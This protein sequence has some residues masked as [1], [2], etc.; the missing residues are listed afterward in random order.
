MSGDIDP[1][2]RDNQIDTPDDI[3]GTDTS[4]PIHST[5]STSTFEAGIEKPDRLEGL[6]TPYP[7]KSCPAIDTN[8][9]TL[10]TVR[11]KKRSFL[12]HRE[13]RNAFI[14]MIALAVIMVGIFG[15]FVVPKTTL[16]VRTWYSEG[17]FGTI[18]V[19]VLI[20]NKAPTNIENVHVTLRIRNE[21]GGVVEE[22]YFEV[23]E[24]RRW[25]SYNLPGIRIYGDDINN[26]FV[27]Y[28][29]ILE[30]AF[31]ARGESRNEKLLHVTE[32]PYMTLLFKDKI[33]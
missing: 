10:M 13:K 4:S 5:H 14:A 7:T 30:I 23:S 12:H 33:D 3:D 21:S 20:R 25:Q 22:A 9:D 1:E 24:I 29:I 27:N 16:E 31:T 2:P 15:A 18:N 11:A 6:S 32:E 17:I 8:E 26:H 28:T 19:D